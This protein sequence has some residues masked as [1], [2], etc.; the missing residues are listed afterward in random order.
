MKK[1]IL[2][3]AALLTFGAAVAQTTVRRTVSINGRRVTSTDEKKKSLKEIDRL[4]Y[5]ITYRTQSA[6]DRDVKDTSAIDYGLD[7][8]RL[9]IGD[10]TSK[11]YSYTDLRHDSLMNEQA[12]KGDLNFKNVGPSGALHWTVFRN[13]PEGKTL[14]LTRTG[15]DNYRIVEDTQTP[16]W[17]IVGDSVKTILG[18]PCTLAT[19]TFKGR[20]WRAWYTEDI[21]LDNGP[22]KLCGLPGLILS[23]QDTEA[24]FIF[25][26]VG[27][28][29][30]DGSQPITY[31]PKNDD[32]E[33]ITFS[34]FVEAQRR[35]TPGSMLNSMSSGL[36]KVKITMM[37]E[38]G[39][40]FSETEMQQWLNKA[41]PYNP[42]ER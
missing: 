15:V 4:A 2:T 30:M 13:Y 6:E 40:E 3:F 10:R 38:D 41:D 23:A 31:D 32:D 25:E 21:P 11:F 22:W 12:A 37:H 18:Y 35:A 33:Q 28:Q 17:D 20:T 34:E 5:R 26:A 1:L 8:M 9:D 36:G 42:I 39:T 7:D 14:L 19:T 27:L 24:H 16:D 29:Q